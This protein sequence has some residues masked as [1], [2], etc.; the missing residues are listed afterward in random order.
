[1]IAMNSLQAVFWDYPELTNWET[2]RQVVQDNESPAKRQWMLQ[3]FLEHGRVIDT[4]NLFPLNVIMQEFSKLK[5][6]PYTF[7]KWARII[8]VYAQPTRE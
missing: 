2:L 3:R 5:L 1:M 8:E 4:L 7:R 6:R